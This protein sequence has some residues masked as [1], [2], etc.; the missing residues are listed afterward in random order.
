[1]NPTPRDHN[2]IAAVAARLGLV[3][4]RQFG[5]GMFGAALVS[6]D[7]G[8]ELVLKARPD[9]SLEPTWRTGATT[10]ELMRGRGYPSPRYVDVGATDTAVWSLQERLPGRDT[11]RLTVGQAQ[12][13]VELARSHNF[14]SGVRRSWRDEAIAA[15]RGWLAHASCESDRFDAII[16]RAADAEMFET[17]V[18]HGDFH[19]RNV[20]VEGET[21][22]GVFDWDI[23]GPGDWRFDLAMLLFA[24]LVY[25]AFSEPSATL[26]VADALRDDAPDEV[27]SF[28][29]ACQVLRTLSM[30]ASFQPDKVEQFGAQMTDA[31]GEWLR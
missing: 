24:C 3:V 6:N 15:C 4:T 5:N 22:T 19:H 16:E 8:E 20:L 29:L 10:S 17:T 23:A 2:T 21:V 13:L 1:M 31:L 7:A 18:V 11:G 27:S 9:T 30:A 28:L 14:D 12:Q 25:P 26:V